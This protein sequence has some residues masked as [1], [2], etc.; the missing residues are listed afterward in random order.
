LR[1]SSLGRAVNGDARS[2]FPF[3]MV[4]LVAQAAV[5]NPQLRNETKSG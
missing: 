2:A 4:A 5:C 1:I 3:A